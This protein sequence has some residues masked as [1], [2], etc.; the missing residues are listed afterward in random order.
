[1]RTSQK[2][3]GQNQLPV[4]MLPEGGGNEI[5]C[6]ARGKPGHKSNDSI[7]N[8]SKGQVWSGA[9]AAFK[10]KVTDNK[11]PKGYGKGGG[12]TARAPCPGWVALAVPC[13]CDKERN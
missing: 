4:M 9:P 7:C 1:L 3:K 6:H 2:S 13:A 8:A 12:V 10:A 11:R 5:T